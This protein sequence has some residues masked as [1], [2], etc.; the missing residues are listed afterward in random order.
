MVNHGISCLSVANLK[1]MGKPPNM[2][3]HVLLF[4]IVFS[5]F[6]RGAAAQSTADVAW[7]QIAA[8]PTLASALVQAESYASTLPDVN[9]FSLRGGWYAITLGPYAPEDAAA[10]LSNY[11]SRGLIPS[12]SYVALTGTYGQQYWPPGVDV[13]GSGSL[14]VTAP[15]E[16]DPDTQTLS[17]EQLPMSGSVETDETPS[18][19]RRGERLLSA[20]ERQQLQI[21]LQW[22]G[23]YNSTIDGAFGR[24][25]RNSMAAWQGANGFEPTGVLTTRQRATLLGQYNAVLDGLDMQLVRDLEAGIEMR[26]PTAVVG[27]SR[28]EAPF[29]HYNPTG[30]LPVRVLLISQ[31]GGR[32]TL[33]SLYDIMQTLT[34]VPLN[35]PR[36]LTTQGFS[37]AGRTSDFV[38]E[39][40]VSI[41]GEE[42]KG[43]TLIWPADDE[44]RRTRVL[45]E[46]RQSFVRRTSVLDPNA[47][48]TAEQSI[49]LIS[50]LEIRKPLLSRS[51]F[52]VD[53]S[54]AVVTT[55]DA[56][57][58][59]TRITLDELH[60]ATLAG[61]DDDRGIA[62]LKPTSSLAP[63]AVARFSTVPPRLQSEIAVAG[64]SFEG[65]LSA[66][67]MT[68]G[69]LS[70][71][72]GLLG[73][74]ELSRLS[75]A[76]LPGDA[77][78]PVFDGNGN[79][80]GMLLPQ[81]SGTRQLPEEVS[82]AL[83]SDAIAAVLE[84][85]GLSASRSDDSANL[86][87]VDLAGRGAGMTVLVSCWE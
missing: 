58:S 34:V 8:R 20:E 70:D 46:M 63:P 72:R 55:A 41:V 39:T 37:I 71:L 24:G 33:K 44:T 10:V 66:P 69:T 22:A 54:G 16:A 83:S 29:A 52:Y 9:G 75:L 57:R 79:V 31:Q 26:M 82:F 40:E 12:D 2:L 13:L 11:R 87:P 36:R 35:G 77:G 73:E 67:T 3:R 81:P 74:P 85:A 21:A 47:G 61:V 64:Y 68:F 27:F 14:A 6:P 19:A 23:Y 1:T 25:T 28:Y 84:R 18:E 48:N 5:S 4:L 65:Q 17:L 32:E 56:V 78:G 53:A 45:Q 43:F 49:D 30:D 86:D 59:C 42:I 62:V 60:D 15:V 50:G 38:S 80:F 76:A 7:V 51:G